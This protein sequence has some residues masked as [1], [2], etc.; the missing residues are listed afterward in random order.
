MFKIKT[1][2]SI[3]PKGLQVFENNSYMLNESDNPDGILL[4]SFNL[5]DESIAQSV[6]AI[7][8]AGVGVNNIP[9]KELSEQG[10][11][12][13][14][15]PGANANAVK[16]LVLLSLFV[17]SR[18]FLPAI[19]WTNTLKIDNST[20]IPSQ[21]ESGKKQFVGNEIRGKRFGVIGVGAIG[22]LVAN[23]A[24]ALGMDVVA[25]DPF[26]S[27]NTAWQ[28]SSN[29]QR[30]HNMDEIFSTCDYIT[31][32]VPLTD[33]TR[34]IIDEAAIGKM[35]TGVRL[36][37]FS[38]AELVNVEHLQDALEKEKIS[39][40]ITDF[41]T[42]KLLKMKNVITIPHLGAST[43]EAEENCAFMA[44]S[45]LKQYLETGNIQHSVNFPNVYLPFTRLS[46]VTVA[47]KNIPN[48]VGQITAVLAQYEMNIA[49]MLNSSK[50]LWA[51]TIIDLDSKAEH[52]DSIIQKLLTID[53]IKKVRI[54][55]NER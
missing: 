18:N 4:R 24:L 46:R 3:A 22:V 44:A 25:Y 38:R 50:D 9:V 40:Y 36:L 27:V 28:L 14:N 1:Y 17:S 48:M 15:T 6:K 49:N 51:Y 13:F 47:H 10:V 30:A 5:H 43:V 41:P 16:E 8:R 12:V 53:G 19:E 21:V 37:N 26:I 33:K 23:D 35:K 52:K 31:L 2:N 29:V 54:I 11:V 39:N 42:E 7:A 55:E 45:T 34:N 32:H 20:S